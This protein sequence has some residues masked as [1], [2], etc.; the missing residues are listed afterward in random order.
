MS[1]AVPI[2]GVIVTPEPPPV[3]GVVPPPPPVP[4]PVVPHTFAAVDE[5]RGKGAP[6]MKSDELLSASVH[7]LTARTRA[8]VLLR[9]GAGVPSEQFALPYPTKSITAVGQDELRTIELS[10]NT[11]LPVVALRF[12]PPLTS[13]VGRFAVPPA[14]AASA[15]R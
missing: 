10:T 14:P 4:P 15:I 5:L 9:V 11:T 8:V 6:L 7:P 2:V 3:P 1:E 12:V 13:A